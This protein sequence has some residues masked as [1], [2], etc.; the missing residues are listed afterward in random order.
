[1]KFKTTTVSTDDRELLVTVTVNDSDSSLVVST[2][3]YHFPFDI[4]PPQIAHQ[5]ASQLVICNS[6][7]VELKDN[8]KVSDTSK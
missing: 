7:Y 4:V 6:Y 1:M 8:E 5:I 2:T 3:I